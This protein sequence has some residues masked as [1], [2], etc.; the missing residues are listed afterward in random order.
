MRLCSNKFFSFC[1]FFGG[2]GQLPRTSLPDDSSYRPQRNGAVVFTASRQNIQLPLLEVREV[3][4]VFEDLFGSARDAL[5]KQ[6]GGSNAEGAPTLS[7]R[8]SQPNPP[9]KPAP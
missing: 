9:T 2:P 6:C 3:R 4:R 5:V 1:S 7:I 8:R